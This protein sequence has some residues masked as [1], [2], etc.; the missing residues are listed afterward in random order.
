[1]IALN[2]GIDTSKTTTNTQE[3]LQKLQGD[4]ASNRTP[5]RP[6]KLRD[7]DVDDLVAFLRTLTDPCIKSAVCLADWI[8][9]LA[10]DPNGLQLDAQFN[11]SKPTKDQE[12]G[13]D[14][15]KHH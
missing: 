11:L 1:V 12:H 10:E 8:P 3:A 13:H 2:P 14:Q 6:T 15:G 9:P 7:Q 5:L 4:I